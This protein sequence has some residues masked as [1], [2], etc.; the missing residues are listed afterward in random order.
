MP[1]VYSGIVEF[2]GKPPNG[3][4][5]SKKYK[6]FVSI[7]WCPHFNNESKSFVLFNLHKS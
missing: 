6:G 1:G 3:K 2:I 5:L 4:E 7:G